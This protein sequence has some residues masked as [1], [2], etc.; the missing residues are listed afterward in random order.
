MTRGCRK[1]G[2]KVQESKSRENPHRILIMA[3]STFSQLLQTLG[4]FDPSTL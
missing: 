3:E 2:R 4:L 1:R